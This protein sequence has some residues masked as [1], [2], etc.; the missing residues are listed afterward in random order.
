MASDEVVDEPGEPRQRWH[1][2]RSTDDHPT[3]ADCSQG[4]R[5]CP[6]PASGFAARFEP[7]GVARNVGSGKSDRV[8]IKVLP[9]D[10]SDVR[11]KR[12]AHFDPAGESGAESAFSVEREHGPL[13]R[14]D[15]RLSRWPRSFSAGA[16]QL[17]HRLV[18]SRRDGATDLRWTGATADAGQ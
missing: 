5:Y 12:K 10:D 8:E 18:P 16:S 3:A 13:N 17:T 2:E 1:L 11:F 7:P 14:L 15:S 4:S 9:R 6:V